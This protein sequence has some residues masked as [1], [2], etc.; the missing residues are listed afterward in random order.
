MMSDN[1][2]AIVPY[3]NI[4]EEAYNHYLWKRSME[5]SKKMDEDVVRYI[6]EPLYSIAK[7]ILM[8]GFL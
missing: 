8:S 7:L 5:I 1:Q 6:Y 3:S 4:L 2:Y